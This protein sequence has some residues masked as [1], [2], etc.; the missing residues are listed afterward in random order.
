MHRDGQSK[1]WA[2]KSG[3]ER[4]YRIRM[5]FTY[6]WYDRRSKVGRAHPAKFNPRDRSR[7][8]SCDRLEHILRR[9]AVWG[10][11]DIPS[12]SPRRNVTRA[13]KRARIDRGFSNSSGSAW[14]HTYTRNTIP[15]A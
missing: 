1:E 8:Q 4:A 11:A 2:R 3:P 15:L 9:S 7:R 6:L 10:T 13:E 5:D 14:G 12:R